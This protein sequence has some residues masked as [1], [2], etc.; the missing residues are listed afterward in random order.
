[1]NQSYYLNV[2][3]EL[4][5]FSEWCISEHGVWG[6]PIPYFVRHDTG[7]VLMDAEIIRHV[8]DVF[9]NNQGADAWYHLPVHDLLPPKYRDISSNYIKG[10]QIFDCWFDNSLSW[11]YALL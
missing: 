11:D 2:V 6:L 3:E 10:N 8:A 9:K 1:V 5:D 7:E 4:N